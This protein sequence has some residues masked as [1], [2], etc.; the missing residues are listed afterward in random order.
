MTGYDVKM[1]YN[2]AGGLSL[3][4]DFMQMPGM[5]GI[6][7]LGSAGLGGEIDFLSMCRN[8]FPQTFTS[9]YQP[10][11]PAQVKPEEREEKIKELDKKVEEAKKE[12]KKEEAAFD[13]KNKE[14]SAI[15]EKEKKYGF[16][17]GIKSVGSG[18]AGIVTDLVCEK[19]EKGERVLSGKRALTSLL[20]GGPLVAAS[21]L[22]PPFGVALAAIGTVASVAQAGKGIYDMSKAK[23]YE[24]KDAAVQEMAQGVAGGVLSCFGFSAARAAQAVKAAKAAKSLVGATEGLTTAANEA[25][26]TQTVKATSALGEVLR[27][28][29]ELA[30][31]VAK[32]KDLMSALTVAAK[33]GNKANL[34]TLE[35]ALKNAG[36]NDAEQIASLTGIVK[37]ETTARDAALVEAI[38]EE[39]ALLQKVGRDSKAAKIGMESLS[40]LLKTTAKDGGISPELEAALA[41]FKTGS[42]EAAKALGFGSKAS[43][44]GKT[45]TN[46]GIREARILKGLKG[47][48]GASPEQETVI[49]NAITMLENLNKKGVGINELKDTLEALQGCE[50]VN[51]VTL[52]NAITSVLKSIKPGLVENAYAAGKG[53]VK[54]V[55]SIPRKVASGTRMVL[56][57]PIRETAKTTMSVNAFNAQG[58]NQANE[59]VRQ[60]QQAHTLQAL[61]LV[62]AAHKDQVTKV[63]NVHREQ[64]EE[65]A[66]IYGISVRDD[67]H[68]LKTDAQL[69][70]E[71]NKARDKEIADKKAKAAAEAAKTAKAK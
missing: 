25:A 8:M 26:T 65:L 64:L 19:N 63:K 28:N 30:E 23:T 2:G 31:V 50:S 62:I 61:D 6:G 10:T 32:N 18:I 34:G 22:C 1:P 3:G 43:E 35:T 58:S 13:T 46:F 42:P 21:I 44:A 17:A 40:E 59:S 68:E 56:G 54:A 24:D 4:T 71:I 57:N 12:V 53:T 67:K 20:I 52:V 16:W 37:S 5:M 49:K 39:L 60:D 41:K 66:G 33:D 48:T 47:I 69:I 51:D 15:E 45:I 27:N 7:G 70:K 14:K 38:T 36:I 29:T 55:A 9:S 11:A